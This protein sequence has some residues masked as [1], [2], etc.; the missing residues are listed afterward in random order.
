[1][2]F[3]RFSSVQSN[4]YYIMDLISKT[5]MN[6]HQVF[7]EQQNKFYLIFSSWKISPIGIGHPGNSFYL[8]C[9]G[10]HCIPCKSAHFT[11]TYP[12]NS[13]FPR[14]QRIYRH[15]DPRWLLTQQYGFLRTQLAVWIFYGLVRILFQR[16]LETRIAER[17]HIYPLSYVIAYVY[18]NFLADFFKVDSLKYRGKHLGVNLLKRAISTRASVTPYTE[19]SSIKSIL[20]STSKSF[21]CGNALPEL[22]RR[23]YKPNVT[24]LRP[25]G[26]CRASRHPA[27]TGNCPPHDKAV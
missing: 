15:E 27:P 1:M 7:Q 20:T 8:S 19:F 11:F 23:Q 26:T 13:T 9:L 12:G 5:Q 3:P 16:T 22:P 6:G 25:A 17:A 18:Q 14:N 21:L 2:C 4:F 24:K 10:L